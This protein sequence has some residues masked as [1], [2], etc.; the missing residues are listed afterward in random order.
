MKKSWR[1]IERIDKSDFFGEKKVTRKN[2]L[3]KKK[4]KLISINELIKK[5]LNKA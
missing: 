1:I 3:F 2:N 5:N 4:G